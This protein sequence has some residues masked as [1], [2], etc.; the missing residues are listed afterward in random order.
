MSIDSY[1][2]S[3]KK[4]VLGKNTVFIPHKYIIDPI[5]YMDDLQYKF[6]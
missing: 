2:P 1:I 4:H 6:Q 5:F 3:L